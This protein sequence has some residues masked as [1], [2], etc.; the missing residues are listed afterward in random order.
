MCGVAIEVPDSNKPPVPVP[1]A[2]ENTLTP[3]AAALGWKKLSPYRGP[4]DENDA[5]VSKAGFVTVA[6]VA[7]AVAGAGPPVGPVSAVV[8]LCR[9][10]KNGI[11]TGS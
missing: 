1:E 11:V 6:F 4:P 7:V 2:V 3:G 9:T 5:T 8:S 10:P